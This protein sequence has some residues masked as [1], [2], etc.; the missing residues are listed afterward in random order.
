MCPAGRSARVCIVAAVR[1]PI[2]GFNGQ[3][4][5]LS[6]TDL[7]AHAIKQAVA[8][9]GIDAAAVQECFMGNVYSAGL[10]QVHST[11]HGV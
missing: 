6:A 2:G 8:Q 7:G 3:L 5:A 9:A 1:T 4:S 10:G 11:V